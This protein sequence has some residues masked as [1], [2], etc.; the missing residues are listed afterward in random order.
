MHPLISTVRNFIVKNAPTILM[1]S[2]IA[3]VISTAALAAKAASE[4]T[5]KIRNK[6]V[7]EDRTLSKKECFKL[8]WHMYIPS[9]IA[10]GITVASIV[11]HNNVSA[12]RSA[13]I[14]SLYTASEAT[15]RKY[16]EKVVEVVGKNGEKRISDESK[17]EIV[18]EKLKDS[19]H[20]HITGNGETI[21]YDEPSDRPFKS[22]MESIRRVVNDINRD[23]LHH[24]YLF[25]NSLYTRLGLRPTSLGDL[26]GWNTNYP[27]DIEYVAFLDETN[28]PC[29]RLEYQVVYNP[30]KF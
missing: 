10:M 25:L 4:A 30:S 15:L 20:I 22:D 23:I 9:V 13:A 19:T 21:F 11:T 17:S 7:F 12:R 5:D 29:I 1:A 6:E 14:L 8:T 24:D 18:K 27:L 3:G 26:V 28:K 2:G 16:K